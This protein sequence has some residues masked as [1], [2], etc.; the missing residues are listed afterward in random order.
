MN[1]VHEI[2]IQEG[3]SLQILVRKFDQDAPIPTQSRY[4]DAGYNIPIACDIILA[5]GDIK[6]VPSGLGFKIPHGFVGILRE[7]SGTG[8][9]GLSVKGGVI[10]SGY[11]G[12]IQCI[13]QNTKIAG[14]IVI[15]KWE[16]PVQMI[17]TPVLMMPLIVVDVL[18][19][20][21]RGDK[22]FGSTGKG[23]NKGTKRQLRNH[24]K[25]TYRY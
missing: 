14:E 20:T 17:I 5:P 23:G 24:R 19:E 11:I 18:P 12:E 4:G 1:F 3:N 22:G 15:N 9:D 10:D 25:I 2:T 7:R 21:D 13:L 16:C 6:T 8:R